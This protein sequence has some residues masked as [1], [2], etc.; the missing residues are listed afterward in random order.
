MREQRGYITCAVATA[1][2]F[3]MPYR[4]RPVSEP[5]EVKLDGEERTPAP[6]RSGAAKKLRAE[7][8][9]ILRR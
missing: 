4:A 8:E 9:K 1:N 6:M 5:E 2:G 3:A 7:I